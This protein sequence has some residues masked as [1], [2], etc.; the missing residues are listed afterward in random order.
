M[1]RVSTYNPAKVTVTLKNHSASGFAEDSFV[2]VE[3]ISDG[4]ESQSGADGEVVR[5]VDPDERYTVKLTLQQTSRTNKWLRNM[6]EKDKKKGNAIFPL[7]IKD[8]MGKEQF[9]AS[10]A[11]VKK[12][13]SWKRGK[14]A[15]DIEWE[16]ECIG[17][18]SYN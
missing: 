6:Y 9:K 2:E 10:K 15:G 8:G 14:K 5:S 13:S 1:A 4:V 7:K 12:P 16:L 18:L 17:Q 3:P 11:W